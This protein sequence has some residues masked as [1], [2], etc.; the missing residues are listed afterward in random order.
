MHLSPEVWGPVFWCTL[1]IISLA[2][3]DEPTYAEKRSAKDF[4]N[5][6]AHLLPCPVCREHFREVLQGM[7]IEN[8]L[9]NRKSLVEW[10]W[11]AHNRVNKSL[12]KREI[13]L[14]EF[15]AAYKEMAD[16]GLPIPPAS[17]TAEINDAAQSAAFVRGASYAAGA[18]G[19]VG[20]VGA[21]LWVS[22][23]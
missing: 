13:T 19:V 11:T 23:K 9:D 20:V 22:Y 14:E 12:G 5:A 4:F 17:P 3:P 7:P 8:W 2:Y 1:H 16:R 15:Y 18:I 6:L 21:L 10:V